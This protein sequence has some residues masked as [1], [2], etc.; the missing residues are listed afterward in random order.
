MNSKN[1]KPTRMAILSM[2]KKNGA[3]TSKQVGKE[4]GV[5]PM[6]A[7]QHLTAMEEE[8]VL[9]SEFKKQK[10][11]RPSLYFSLTDKA[12][13]YFPQMYSEL[14]FDLLRDMVSEGG[15]QTVNSVIERR[16]KTI[17]ETYKTKINGAQ[18]LDERIHKLVELRDHDGYM[19][20]LK[21]ENGDYLLVEHNCPIAKIAKEFPEICHHEMKLF[22][23]LLGVSLER[24]DHMMEGD[25]VCMYRILKSA[26]EKVSRTDS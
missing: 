26:Q 22:K 4:L 5:T 20:D 19:A 12:D 10:A 13:R 3:M 8:G 18:G 21:Q 11:G 16:R 2:L 17:E 25:H 14:A 24:Q 23:D 1:E 7:R 15:R 9:S 6:G